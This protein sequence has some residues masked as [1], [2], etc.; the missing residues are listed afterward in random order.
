MPQLSVIA[1][2]SPEKV[3]AALTT[4]VMQTQASSLS[5]A[6][7]RA[8][9]EF[10]TGKTL[11]AEVTKNAFC[12][13][14]HGDLKDALS[15]SVW[16]GW[17]VDMNNSRFQ[18]VKADYICCFERLAVE[19]CV[20]KQYVLPSH[21][22]ERRLHGEVTTFARVASRAGQNVGRR[23]Q[24]VGQPVLP[25]AQCTRQPAAVAIMEINARDGCP[26]FGN[27]QSRIGDGSS[28]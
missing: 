17:G 20:E 3:L 12:K 14:S 26:C 4:G 16:N 27:F 22:K 25:A 13:E 19:M 1:G 10:L 28:K 18:H 2:M 8:V 21:D 9:S 6:E 7:R 24:S 5:V 23:D 11:G 15:A